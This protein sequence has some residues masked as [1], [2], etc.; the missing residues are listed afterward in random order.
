MLR[1]DIEVLILCGGFGTRLSS[2]SNG[3][4]KG[5]M[6]GPSGKPFILELVEELTQFG[7]KKIILALGYGSQDYID[8]FRAQIRASASILFSV[9]TN[10]LGTGGAIINALKVISGKTFFVING[11]TRTNINYEDMLAFHRQKDAQV[12]IS[13]LELSEDRNDVGCIQ[14]DI[15]TGALMRF[16]EK[17]GVS[18]CVNAGIY[19][20]ECE[21]FQNKK[22]TISNLS[23][24]KTL[25]PD[26]IA[27]KKRIYLYKFT[28]EMYDIGTPERYRRYVQL[29]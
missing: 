17:N 8:F 21:I 28:G 24:E 27:A 22:F 16:Q 18:N 9:E 3:T 1:D 12:T 25:I 14:Y 15:N 5:L 23:L 13:G 7:F 4:P 26:L 6:K 20:F 19:L 2:I 29:K 11:D 10:P